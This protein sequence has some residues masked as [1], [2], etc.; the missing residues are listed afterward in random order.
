MRI[1]SL[2]ANAIIN[3]AMDVDPLHVLTTVVEHHST[4]S[5]VANQYENGFGGGRANE[6]RSRSMLGELLK[7]LPEGERAAVVAKGFVCD[8]NPT[9][10]MA[11]KK[12]RDDANA[13]FQARIDA[14]E[15]KSYYS[16]WVE[17]GT[18]QYD[19]VGEGYQVLNEY[20]RRKI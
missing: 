19:A 1:T 11:L 14:G 4:D 9:V 5:A 13:A 6:F 17:R 10:A 7:L 15:I 2:N 20:G 8:M 3:A 12:Q 16:G 18:W